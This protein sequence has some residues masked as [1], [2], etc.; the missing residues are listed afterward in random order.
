MPQGIANSR[1]QYTKYWTRGTAE[2]RRTA[3]LR[4]AN[5]TGCFTSK[6]GLKMTAG[7]H[8]TPVESQETDQK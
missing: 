8:P 1:F 7:I 6:P 2:S 4:P 5:R 3:A